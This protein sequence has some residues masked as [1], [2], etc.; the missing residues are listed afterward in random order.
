MNIRK[1]YTIDA[2][3]DAVWAALTDPETIARWGGGPAVMAAAPGFE[4]SLW[5]G[6]I[7]GKVI[8]V[9]PG[10]SMLQEWYGGEWESPSLASFAL[11]EEPGGA[12]RLELENTGV[13]DADG[14]DIDT[15]WDD[16]YLGPIKA[17]LEGA[18]A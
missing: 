2:P 14:A 9:D 5:D 1:S 7:H 18:A 16:Y 13:P 12:T 10:R 8:E 17:L 15:G 3:R 11:I 4:F 6:D